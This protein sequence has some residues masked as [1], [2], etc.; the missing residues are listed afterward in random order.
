MPGQKAMGEEIAS[1]IPESGKEKIRKAVLHPETELLPAPKPT[2]H[3]T[4]YLII[5]I[6][7]HVF[8]AGYQ[9]T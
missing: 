1:I 9:F 8:D 7:I 2:T 3:W 6:L 4:S 5:S